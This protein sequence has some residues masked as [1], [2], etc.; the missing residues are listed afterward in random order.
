MGRP[1]TGRPV[2][3][4]TKLTPE[5]GEALAKFV[6]TGNNIDASCALVGV[7]KRTVYDWLYKGV[8]D[9][10]GAYHDFAQLMEKAKA[11]AEAVRV[12]RIG[13]AGAAGE[14]TADAWWLERVNPERWGRKAVELNVN[15]VAS[16]QWIEIRDKIA[17]A[18]EPYPEAAEAVARALAGDV[19]EVKA[20]AAA[21]GA[22]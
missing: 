21:S 17:A 15:L 22:A 1:K 10:K 16:P 18:L 3:A 4:P 9:K 2:G 20:L 19:V 8:N 12:G 11:E 14:W 5:I 6:R 7:G 13:Q